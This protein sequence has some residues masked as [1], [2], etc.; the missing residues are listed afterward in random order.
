MPIEVT[1]LQTIIPGA[2]NPMVVA[3]KILVDGEEIESV[4]PVVKVVIEREVCKIP[5][6]TITILDGDVSQQTFPVSNRDVFVPGK[7]IEIKLGYQ[8]TAETVFKGIIVGHGN[9]ISGTNMELTVTCRDAAVK[10]T[11]AKKNAHYSDIT[12][13]DIAEQT[14]WE[15]H[16]PE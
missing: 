7:S 3:C 5:T 10:L 12:D 15:E 16:T 13:S 1:E 8:A 9:S 14:R 4:I 6:A 11:V 2:E